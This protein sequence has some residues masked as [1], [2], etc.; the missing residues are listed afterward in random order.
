[1]SVDP[2]QGPLYG[3]LV[4][5]DLMKADPASGLSYREVQMAA[6][7]EHATPGGRFAAGR[8]V[9]AQLPLRAVPPGLLEPAARFRRCWRA[10]IVPGRRAR[11]QKKP[12]GTES[13]QG[14]AE[15]AD[16][17]MPVVSP[18]RARR[19]RARPCSCARS[20]WS[21]RRGPARG[22]C[23]GRTRR[24]SRRAPCARWR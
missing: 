20:S 7:K 9:S 12:C 18:R 4:R 17:A 13:P 6:L 15:C 21:A 23:A 19:T 11:A 2:F 10:V 1:M 22:T 24:G 14:L 16:P 3:D 5:L 8:R